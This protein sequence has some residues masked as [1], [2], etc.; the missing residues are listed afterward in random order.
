MV[1]LSQGLQDLGAQRKRP[2]L[3]RK[4]STGQWKGETHQAEGHVSTHTTQNTLI[5]GSLRPCSSDVGQEGNHVRRT[6]RR[7]P[8]RILSCASQT[9]RRELRG[10]PIE[11]LSQFIAG[12]YVNQSHEKIH[13]RFGKQQMHGEIKGNFM[14]KRQK[15]RKNP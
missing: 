4:G 3:S 8:P 10:L 9:S 2:E 11:K 6:N 14:W 1:G 5:R 12:N 7:K 13:S 15:L